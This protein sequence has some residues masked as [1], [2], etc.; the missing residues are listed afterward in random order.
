[1]KSSI[2]LLATIMTF[3]LS[4]ICKIRAEQCNI[5]RSFQVLGRIQLPAWRV[6]WQKKNR[7]IFSRQFGIHTIRHYLVSNLSAKTNNKY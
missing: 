3:R 7:L 5:R 4:N 1:M 6:P 2:F